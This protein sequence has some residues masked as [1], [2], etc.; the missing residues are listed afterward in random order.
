MSW[1]VPTLINNIFFRRFAP[2]IPEILQEFNRLAMIFSENELDG[3]A[4]L[5]YQG[6]ARCEIVRKSFVTEVH[7]LLKA[8][9]SYTKAFNRRLELGYP[10]GE[11]E[12][13]QGALRCYNDILTHDKLPDNSPMRAACIRR[14]KTIDPFTDET[15]TF[16][17]PVHRYEDL[18]L[19]ANAD[20]EQKNYQG[21]LNKLTDIFDDI[22]ERKVHH[23]YWHVLERVEI[24][25]LLL[26]LYLEMPPAALAPS[27]AA[28]LENYRLRPDVKVSDRVKESALEPELHLMFRALVQ[29][30]Q[31]RRLNLL[32]DAYN[33]IGMLH[34]LTLEQYQILGLVFDK[35]DYEFMIE[36]AE[37]D[38]DCEPSSDSSSSDDEQDEE[39]LTEGEANSSKCEESSKE[40]VKETSKPTSSTKEEIPGTSKDGQSENILG[41]E[42]LD[43]TKID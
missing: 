42:Q 40:I 34:F 27:N 6:A 29:S 3:Y 22:H 14:L 37:E 23:C 25:R 12:F 32:R 41:L 38:C 4:A 19:G 10:D 35:F 17:S 21:A 18:Q 31:L 39:K 8:A 26:L 5:C 13:R 33:D 43:I 16:E 30:I 36:R 2:K 15:S 20:I 24:L 11:E 1:I 9:D 7:Y 28:L